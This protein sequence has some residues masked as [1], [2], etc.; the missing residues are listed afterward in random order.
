[1]S[2]AQDFIL[3]PEAKVAWVAALRDPSRKQ[4]RGCLYDENGMCCL[5][6]AADI[7]NI[8]EWD[9]MARHTYST[10]NGRESSITPVAVAEWLGFPH[11]EDNAVATLVGDVVQNPLIP[12]L[13]T[14]DDDGDTLASLND[15]GLT[16]AQI[17]DVI[18]YFL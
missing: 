4:T 17:A 9:S 14:R 11:N 8:G 7:S 6:V 13:N 12:G 3:N 18:E 10:P 2:D 1:M 15:S 5:G 16:F